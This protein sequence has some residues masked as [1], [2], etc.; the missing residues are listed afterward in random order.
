VVRRFAAVLGI[1]GAL[2]MGVMSPAFAG[3]GDSS[4]T[5]GTT[6]TTTPPATLPTTPV[7]TPRS[8]TVAPAPSSS[9]TTRHGTAG[10]CALYGGPAGF[11]VACAGASGQFATASQ[12]LAGHPLPGCWDGEDGDGQPLT[13]D[14]LDGLDTTAFDWYLQTCLT[15]MNPATLQVLPGGVKFSV[16]VIFLP[17][18]AKTCPSSS[19][20]PLTPDPCVIVLDANQKLLVRA[21]G[22]D[23]GIP[24]PTALATPGG[25]VVVN[26]AIAFKDET[27]TKV[28]PIA[29]GGIQ[30][31]A[32]MTSY[33]VYPL[34]RGNGQDSVSC[35]GTVAAGAH[36]SPA[37]LPSACWYDYQQ[38]SASQPGTKFGAYAV[39]SW[40][41]QYSL[42]GGANW[43]NFNSFTKTG[44]TL[45]PVS[46]IQTVIVAGD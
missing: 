41:V 38:S 5:G 2:L 45:I 23:Q 46:E 32:V 39:A 22:G 44:D 24:N 16:Q 20:Q 3:V 37:S 29:V 35:S 1:V 28:D 17:K 25:T 14:D 31:Q 18:D 26:K 7:S 30:M 13:G 15:G 19:P 12:I 40:T 33:R 21:Q 11:G 4:P 42:D 8:V 34:G 9:S 6:G 43:T 10:G 36:D 27:A